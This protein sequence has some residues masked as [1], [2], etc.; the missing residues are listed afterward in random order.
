MVFIVPL[1]VKKQFMRHVKKFTKSQNNQPKADQK[2]ASQDDGLFF[3]IPTS[4]FSEKDF[5]DYLTDMKVGNKDVVIHPHDSNKTTT[6]R[7]T[8]ARHNRT[9][10]DYIHNSQYVL[11]P[12]VECDIVTKF[13]QEKQPIYRT[14]VIQL[15]VGY[16]S[17]P[18]NELFK[19]S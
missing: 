2:A 14:A 5:K 18:E 13:I 4:D 12:K 8:D 1:R 10:D 7:V 3:T 17:F 19:D 11:V 9:V 16:T 6:V 15:G